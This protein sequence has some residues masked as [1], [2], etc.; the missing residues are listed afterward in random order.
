MMGVASYERSLSVSALLRSR[1]NQYGAVNPEYPG[2]ISPFISGFEIQAH[3]AAG[4]GTFALDLIRLHWDY[5]L[6][7]EWSTRSTFVEGLNDDGSPNYAPANFLSQAHGWSS[8]PT[9]ALSQWALGFQIETAGGKTWSW[10]PTGDLK[11]VRGSYE[12]VTGNFSAEISL[13]DAYTVTAVLEV[14]ENTTGTL[15][16]VGRYSSIHVGSKKVTP[17][18]E[19]GRSIVRNIVPDGSIRIVAYRERFICSG[20]IYNEVLSLRSDEEVSLRALD[21]IVLSSPNCRLYLT[22][23]ID[24]NVV[25]YN[26]E[27][28]PQWSTESTSRTVSS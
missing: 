23:Q 27:R 8:G 11:T 1:W 20:S 3:F 4:H 25:V 18:F 5:L 9:A 13:P 2:K 10:F 26:R 21:N 14:P 6:H 16:L 17:E 12:T 28:K 24:G 15:G 7:A 22:V 19:N